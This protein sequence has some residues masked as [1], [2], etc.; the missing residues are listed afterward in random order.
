MEGTRSPQEAPLRSVL[1][2]LCGL[3][4][5]ASMD[6]A[7]PA[8]ATPPDKSIDPADLLFASPTRL[9]HIGRVVAPVMIDGQGPFRFVV[10]TG[11]NHSTVSPHLAALLRL[12]PA[13]EASVR[14]T[15]VTGT[16]RLPYVLIDRLQAGD[17]VITHSRMPVVRTSVMAGADGILGT[18]GL[19]EDRII[20]DFQDNRVVITRSHGLSAVSNFLELPA[21]RVVGGVIM[22]PARIGR[23]TV[24]A[25]IDTG[26][27]HTLGNLALEKALLANAKHKGRVTKV[28]GVTKDISSGDL[29]TAP[30]MALG[31]A[32]ISG[33][34]VVYGDFNIFKVWDLQSTP[35]V[36]LGMD[37]LGTVD[38]LIIDFAQARVYLMPSQPNGVTLT[39]SM[40]FVPRQLAPRA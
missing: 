6:L 35:A 16:E 10:D 1:S 32:T 22:V 15:G 26:S 28:Y 30:D 21:R 14:V 3:A 12:T 2:I 18:A 27:A 36:I 5:L 23:V 38:S 39:D 7:L 9:D 13:A 19:S 4:L 37:V 24:S 17:L 29:I 8:S 40:S 20:V 33:P 31:P 34:S 11:A 25:V